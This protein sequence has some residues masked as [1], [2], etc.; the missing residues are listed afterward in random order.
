MAEVSALSAWLGLSLLTLAVIAPAAADGTD[1]QALRPLLLAPSKS[2]PSPSNRQRATVYRS[3]L[4]REIRQLERAQ[5]PNPSTSGTGRETHGRLERHDQSQRHHLP[6]NIGDFPSWRGRP[7]RYTMYAVTLPGFGGSDAPPPPG[8]G[9]G[10]WL[11]TTLPANRPVRCC[12]VYN[13][14]T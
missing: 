11:T 8:D 9:R 1:P 6:S 12:R 5:T 13:A 4:T 7:E 2:A 10:S 14:E 3:G